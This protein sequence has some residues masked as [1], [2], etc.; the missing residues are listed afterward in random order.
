MRAG[1]G[2]TAAT[3]VAA[4]IGDPIAH[5]LSP[6][7]HNAAFAAAGLD[8]VY[9]ALA[10]RAGRGGDAVAAVRTLG[11]GGLSVTTP[12]KAAAAAAVDRLTPTAAALGAVNCVTPD[13]GA[14]LGDNTDGDGFLDALAADPG[15]RPAGRAAVV[16]GAGGAARAVTRALGAAGAASVGVVARSAD[17]AASCA[18][19]AGT[20]GAVVGPGAVGDAE[21]VV[22]ATG[23]GMARGP[24]PFGLEA[25]AFRPGQ[26]V[27]DLVYVPAVTPLIVAA[28]AGGAIARNG[29]GM[30][31][32]Q[33]ARQWSA[34]TGRPAPL[35]AMEAA[36]RP[37]PTGASPSR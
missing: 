17:A 13:G 11:L 25:S 16:L 23:S 10:V 26:V 12:H 15:W 3:R 24:A 2:L 35:E 28:G 20:A 21:L 37:A 8:W 18:A 33:A 5:S 9:V 29:L 14:L 31:L 19:L 27:V 32:H 30:L 1:P 6:A 36:L 22:D 34:W 7:I 4:V